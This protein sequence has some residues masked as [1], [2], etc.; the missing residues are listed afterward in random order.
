MLKRISH[1]TIFPSL[2]DFCIKIP[3][4]ILLEIVT[5]DNPPLTKKNI[6]IDSS[7]RRINIVFLLMVKGPFRIYPPQVCYRKKQ[8]KGSGKAIVLG[9]RCFKSGIAFFGL[10]VIRVDKNRD[11]S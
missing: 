10:H 8:G 5:R 9:N 11:P 6:V 4:P 1:R 7:S 2:D 3:S